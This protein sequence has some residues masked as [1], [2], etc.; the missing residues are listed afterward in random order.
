MTAGDRVMSP[1]IICSGFCDVQR[2]PDLAC[3][4][5]RDSVVAA[6]TLPN[7]PQQFQPLGYQV[8]PSTRRPVGTR[9]VSGLAEWYDCTPSFSRVYLL[10]VYCAR[11]WVFVQRT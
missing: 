1:K 8:L 10:L 9:L 11:E 5:L 4:E 7:A 3:I 6:A 2:S